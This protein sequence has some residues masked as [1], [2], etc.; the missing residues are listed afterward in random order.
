MSFQP[1]DRGFCEC[2]CTAAGGLLSYPRFYDFINDLG[3]NKTEES[4]S[5]ACVA[6]GIS[7]R[8][9]GLSPLGHR[10]GAASVSSH[11]EPD[12][13]FTYTGV[14]QESGAQKNN[15]LPKIATRRAAV[16]YGPSFPRKKKILRCLDFALCLQ[17]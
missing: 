2:L 1:Q 17:L 10:F 16:G 15:R 6:H 13:P 8:R 14:D 3:G 5:G 9:R 4:F 11:E 7:N 12:S